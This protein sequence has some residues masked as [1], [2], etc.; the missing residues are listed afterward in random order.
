MTWGTSPY[1]ITGQRL[2]GHNY[3]SEASLSGG[4]YFTLYLGELPEKGNTEN[5]LRKLKRLCISA[6]ADQMFTP[7]TPTTQP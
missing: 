5:S 2:K 1:E 3:T 4:T 7:E 6:V